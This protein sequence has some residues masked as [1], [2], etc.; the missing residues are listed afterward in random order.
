LPPE[1]GDDEGH[2]VG[3]EAESPNCYQGGHEP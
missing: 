1:L 2:A 3:H